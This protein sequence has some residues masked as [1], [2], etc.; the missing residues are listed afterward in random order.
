MNENLFYFFYSFAHRSL[1]LDHLIY[2]VGKTLPMFV[3][4]GA[5]LFLWK[6]HDTLL[7]PA[8]YQAFFLKLKE[9]S[10]VFVTSGLAWMSAIYLKKIFHTLRPWAMYPNVRAL[11]NEQGF[12]FPSGHTAFFSA[13]AF[14]IFFLHKKTGILFL[15]CALLIGTARVVAGVHF[16]IDIFGGL[17]LGYLVSF[18]MHK[19]F[20]KI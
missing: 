6:H 15:V 20:K 8:P 4:V 10:F 3:V 16:P 1:G 12:A 11:I 18:V 17:M 5:I 14:S 9:V 2:F 13:L 7:A 19:V